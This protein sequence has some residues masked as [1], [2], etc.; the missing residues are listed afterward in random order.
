VTLLNPT[1]GSTVSGKVQVIASA[2]V[3]Q[4]TAIASLSLT[5]DGK[6]LQSG[7][8]AVLTATWDTAK[9][10]AS[11]P[12]VIVAKVVDGAGNTA[13]SAPVTVTVAAAAAADAGGC[14]ASGSPVDAL[15]FGFGLLGLLQ[16]RRRRRFR[17]AD[18]DRS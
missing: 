17:S 3:G 8:D 6:P 9:V 16:L 10:D 14:S 2:H 12:H 11:R 15:T 1:D 7:A 5:V 4:G 13:S 18:A